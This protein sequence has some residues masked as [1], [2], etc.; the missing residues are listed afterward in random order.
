MKNSAFGL[1]AVF[2]DADG[3]LYLKDNA[4][5]EEA[6]NCEFVKVFEDGIISKEYSLA[7]VRAKLATY[8]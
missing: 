7:D 4:T 1:V 6:K 2:K 8:L 3:E 5:W